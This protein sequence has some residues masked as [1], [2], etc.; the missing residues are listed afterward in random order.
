M[1]KLKTL[2]AF[3]VG[4]VL[5]TV[6]F[7]LNTFSA[8][9]PPQASDGYY[10]L[11][12]YEDLVWFQ[13]YVDAGNLEINARL[14]A[15]IVANEN[16]LNDKG[17]LNGT[18][19]NVW[20][21]IGR[22]FTFA[23]NSY[24]G[25]LDGAGHSITGLFFYD[26]KGAGYYGLFAKMGRGTVKN[27]AIVDSFFGGVN[28]SNYVG[29]FVGEG[30]AVNL[31]NCY[32][33]A[34]IYASDYYGGIV[35][36]TSVA[37]IRNC[38]YAGTFRILGSSIYADPIVKKNST[39]NSIRVYNCYYKG[40]CGLNSTVATAVATNGLASGQVT[41]LLNRNQSSDVWRQ[42]IDI[43]EK[44]SEPTLDTN[45]HIVFYNGN[46]YTNYCS[47]HSWKNG[48]CSVC[49]SIEEPQ[50]VDDYYEIG[51]YGN[52]VWFQQYVDA[53]NVNINARLTANIVANENLLDSSGNVQGTPKYNWTPIG[54]GYSN[55][56]D[57]YNG[58]FDGACYS[59]SGLY[60]N[61]TEN[62]CGFF[63]KMNKGTIKNLSIVDSYFGESSCFFVGSF[64]GCGYSYS[65]IENCYSNATTVGLYY[66]GG[67]A[68]ET[69]GTVS[70]CLY[71]GKIK[72]TRNSNAIA[73]DRYNEG[74]ITNCYYNENCGL[75]TTRAKSV[76]DSQLASG[77]VAY[78]LNGDQSAIA[79]YQNVDRGEK[80]NAPTLNS[81]HYRVYK[82]DNIYTND[83]DKHSHVYNNGICDICNKACTHGKYKNGICTYCEYGV[84]EPQLV[85]DYYEIANY[86]NLV[87]FQQ[88]VDAG[89]VNINARLTTNIVANE[90]LLDSSGN[91]QDTPKYNWTP[92]GRVY[93]N[94]SD[95]YN[96][97]FD[98]AGY[99]ISGLYSNGTGDYWGFFGEV[100][101]STIKNL[102]I[103]DSYFGGKGC[104][105][106]GTFIGYSGYDDVNIENCYS[107]A[108][109]VGSGYCGGI[110]GQIKSTVSD[111]LYNGKITVNK[112]SN[113]IASDYG[114]YGKLTNCYY[115]ENCGLSSDRATAVTDEQLASGEVAYLLNSDQ[116]AIKWYQNIDK[117]EKDNAP[118]LSS[119]HYRVYKGDNIYT[120]DLDKH[121]HI[122][123]K[124]ICDICNKVCAH[125]K[126]E[127][128]VCSECN[129][130]VEEPQL[131]DNYYEISSYGNLIWFQRYVDAGNVRVNAKLITNIVAN[132][133]LLD[134]SGNVQDTPKYN[135]TPIGRVYS[136]TSD[137]Y[138]GV[139]DGAGYSIS[140][141]Y[142]NGTGD[143]CGFFG[144]VYKSTIKNLSVLDSYF[145]GTSCLK[146]GTFVGYDWRGGS[147]ENCYSNATIVGSI[148]CGGIVG[149][150]RGTISNCLYNGKI[151]AEGKS[152]AIASDY[153][154]YGKLTN[155]YY[156]EN[157]GLSSDR[158]T[159]VTAAQ[160]SSGEVAYLLNGDQSA[161]AW[162]QNVDK[163]EKDNVPTLN[164]AHYTV[165]KNS[166][167]YSNTL[168][169]DVNN[170]GK[171]DRKDAVLI[172]KN[173]SGITS[174][175][176]SA[177]NA[178]YNGDGVVNSLDAIAIMKSI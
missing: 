136:N 64:V 91:V 130:G 82:G 42:N 39:D 160:L 2:T 57:S 77:E 164:S 6:G 21:P 1:G 98:G 144:K 166:N 134:S 83:L 140:G 47:V 123:N 3:L 46:T 25:I 18:P 72:G 59:I 131:V 30:Y 31:E 169:G 145:G 171:I 137:S 150:T 5:V 65:N 14:T 104:S 152:N 99:S 103:V 50:L 68:G 143:Y 149:E 100:Y 138:N 124:G 44:D 76:T 121:I 20:T 153:K 101:K 176:F 114:G 168:L 53:G 162:Y 15:D 154:S 29:T 111:C 165:F 24:N 26:T 125:E 54:R 19:S 90:N 28:K 133:N 27:L 108:T 40:D 84:E 86:G 172:L 92:I 85:G 94:T 120:N 161:I 112:Y 102:S 79:W 177:E 115:N 51:N 110:V 129:Y 117:G 32:S 81:E 157:C 48:I 67:I 43:G 60:S 52:L 159:A 69:K 17:S 163:G 62:Y 105:N 41:Y 56:S 126:Y 89:N 139:F 75:T 45:H 49:D 37:N 151:I 178:D 135:W 95:S 38:L 170:D 11:D 73:S 122:Y 8:T 173:I 71:N 9:T 33:N 7:A 58:V 22:N 4:I 175:N 36:K 116:S 167:G 142:S 156:N 128:G 78:L 10:E 155:C 127:K 141:L 23:A 88:Y 118:T 147:I 55:S 66:C 113:A 119:E 146:V 132:E 12:S 70:N 34:I 87:W 16:L 74:T 35:G 148:Y 109:I 63:G 158:A 97:V 13:Q 174:D 61:G 96:G 93:S 80:D 106:V 107:S